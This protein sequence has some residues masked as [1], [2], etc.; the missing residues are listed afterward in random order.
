M[1]VTVSLHSRISSMKIIVLPG[2]VFAPANAER[3]KKTSE[4]LFARLSVSR[5]SVWSTRPNLTKCS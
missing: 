4:G 1:K 3:I 2:I 5:M